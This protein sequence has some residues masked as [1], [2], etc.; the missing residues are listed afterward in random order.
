MANPLLP[1][2]IA[3]IGL[4]VY[5]D[6]KAGSS[7]DNPVTYLP[8]PAQ[9]LSV[10]IVYGTLG[11]LPDRFARPAQLLGWGFVIA[12]ALNVFNPA[13]VGNRVQNAALPATGK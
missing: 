12:T 10:V 1:P 2:A 4:I 13:T 6:I 8:R 11:A 7:K 9:L 5:R 3:E